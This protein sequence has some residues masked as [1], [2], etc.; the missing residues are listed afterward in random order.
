MNFNNTRSP[1]MRLLIWREARRR[2]ASRAWWLA[3]MRRAAA[4]LAWLILELALAILAAGTVIF[5]IWLF[6]GGR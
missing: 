3:G 5:T 2:H 6:L 4:D 1:M